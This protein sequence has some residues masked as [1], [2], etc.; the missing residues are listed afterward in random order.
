MLRTQGEF[1][2]RQSL[3]NRSVSEN[4]PSSE[5]KINA[6]ACLEFA[7][8]YHETLDDLRACLLTTTRAEENK[9]ELELTQKRIDAL[10]AE[11]ETIAEVALLHAKN[12]DNE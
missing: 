6:Q 7:P 1:F 8:M 9:D 10:V 12:S 5:L 3:Y 4:R 2:R 11:T